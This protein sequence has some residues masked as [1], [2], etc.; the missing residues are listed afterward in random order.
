MAS[1]NKNRREQ[2]REPSTSRRRFGRVLCQDVSC[3]LGDV[4]DLSAK[5]MRVE[6]RH[7]LPPVGTQ[8]AT[9]ITTLDGPLQVTVTVAWVKKAGWL[10][11][12]VGFIFGKMDTATRDALTLLGRASAHNESMRDFRDDIAKAG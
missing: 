6:T 4:L 1:N 9:T 10:S 11:R 5:G 3:S 8:I 2:P 7:K 12:E